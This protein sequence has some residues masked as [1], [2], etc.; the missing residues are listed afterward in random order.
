LRPISM[1]PSWCRLLLTP[2]SR[3][4]LCLLHIPGVERKS[5]HDLLVHCALKLCTK[6]VPEDESPMMDLCASTSRNS[7]SLSSI[8]VSVLVV[9]GRTRLFPDHGLR[10]PYYL[11]IASTQNFATSTDL[12]FICTLFWLACIFAYLKIPAMSLSL[13][14]QQHL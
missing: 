8:Y 14:L 1:P 9:E 10:L 5:S 2:G 13:A 3:R 7:T 4:K 12:P 11:A 6:A